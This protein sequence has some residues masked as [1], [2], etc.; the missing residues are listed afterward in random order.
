MRDRD[1][2]QICASTAVILD[3]LYPVDLFG[4]IEK[5]FWREADRCATMT[6]VDCY[7][8]KIH[9]TVDDRAKKCTNLTIDS[10]ID[11]NVQMGSM[12]GKRMWVTSTNWVSIVA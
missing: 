6:D 4:R 7:R 8:G 11:R 12:V 1:H 3:N 10:D 9:V 2:F 5:K